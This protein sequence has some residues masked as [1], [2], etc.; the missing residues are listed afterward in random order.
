MMETCVP[1]ITKAV[2]NRFLASKHVTGCSVC[3]R[4]RSF[5]VMDPHTI[6]CGR[7]PSTD[8]VRDVTIDAVA[9]VCENCGTLQFLKRSVVA[10]WLEQQRALWA[11]AACEDRP[12]EIASRR[13]H[14]LYR[15]PAMALASVFLWVLIASL[16][17]H[18]YG[19]AELWLRPTIATVE[20]ASQGATKMALPITY[21]FANER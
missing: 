2:V 14:Q 3:G 4:F 7:M 21:R 19:G 15:G 5:V 17:L 11:R 8:A 18:R 1:E 10:D 20:T 9:I 13:S 6:G 16:L 12:K